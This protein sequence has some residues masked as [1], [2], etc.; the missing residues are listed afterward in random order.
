MS[1]HNDSH[2][3]GGSDAFSVSDLLDAIA[4]VTVRKN[5]GSDVGS[6]RRLNLIEGSNITLTVTD[7]PAAEEVDVTIAASG[8]GTAVPTGAVSQWPTS[9]PPTGWLL[10]DGSAV[11]RTTYAALFGIIGTTYGAGDGSTTFNLPNLK[12]RVPV[13]L[14][15][16]QTEFDAL[17][18]T[19]G[20]KTHT[21]A[22]GEV[23][24][25]DHGAVGNHDHGSGGAHTHDVQG[26]DEGASNLRVSTNAPSVTITVPSA[27]PS[28]GAHTHTAQG[29]HT[30]TSSGGG[31]AHQNLQP[32]LVL[33]YIIKT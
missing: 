4:R 17:G 21:L 20:A 11:S 16:G 9:T 27:A 28:A 1:S 25:H 2:A 24:A 5:S 18:E 22:V 30:H 3:T 7:D 19:G 12:G 14:D 26:S 32:Y 8:G 29:G 31:G 15:A 10:C 23:P 13:G 33:S 6:R